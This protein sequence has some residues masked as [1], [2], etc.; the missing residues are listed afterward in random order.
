M[1][2]SLQAPH[3]LFCST[4][5]SVQLTHAPISN[6]PSRYTNDGTRYASIFN[7]LFAPQSVTPAFPSS[8]GLFQYYS[9]SA[10]G[11]QYTTS[12]L[13]F[14]TVF[15]Y[16]SQQAFVNGFSVPSGTTGM[17]ILAS[18]YGL[19]CTDQVWANFT[20]GGNTQILY[21]S[22]NSPIP[23]NMLPPGTTVYY[24][25]LPGCPSPPPAPPP[26]PLSPPPPPPN[27][28]SPPPPPPSPPPP[29]PPPL[30]P[31]SPSPPPPPPPTGAV[32]LF[33][34]NP[35]ESCAAQGAGLMAAV[36]ALMSLGTDTQA[37]SITCSDV[38]GG[39]VLQMRFTLQT[40]ASNFYV[41]ITST[42]G[43]Q[44]FIYTALN[45]GGLLCGSTIG[46]VDSLGTSATFACSAVPGVPSTLIP[47]LCCAPPPKKS[48]NP[49]PPRSPP[50]PKKSP[51][52]V[53][54]PPSPPPPKKSPPPESPPPPMESPLPPPAII[55]FP[56][57]PPPYPRFP[58]PYL[59]LPCLT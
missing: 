40:T 35:H 34:A 51:P 19:G 10:A 27:P 18:Q 49:P 23:S 31:P 44:Y 38:A 15:N 5:F 6:T 48:P 29:P 36:Q 58:S 53:K 39:V 55:S 56:P 37:S 12:L 1:H 50:P 43:I 24:N 46:V 11:A 21:T 30:P 45:N 22:P 32:T 4:A 16:A 52:P 2:K 14:G 20:C 9:T 42:A 3:S 57:P 28:S 7:Q 54:K 59:A 41:Q 33:I 25:V 13:L 26:P 8:S 47:G 17:Q